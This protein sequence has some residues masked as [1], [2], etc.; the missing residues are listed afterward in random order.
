MHTF[1]NGGGLSPPNFPS[2]YATGGSKANIWG[3]GNPPAPT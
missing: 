3:G 1:L 2:G